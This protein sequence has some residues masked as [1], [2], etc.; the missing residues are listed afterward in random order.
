MEAHSATA[1]VRFVTSL[2]PRNLFQCPLHTNH[3]DLNTFDAEET[4]SP[5]S[6]DPWLVSAVYL[7]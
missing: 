1:T 6:S 4:G 5:L 2:H 3:G 7:A